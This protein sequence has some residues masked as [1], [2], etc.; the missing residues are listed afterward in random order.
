[1]K[2]SWYRLALMIVAI[3][4]AACATSQTARRLEK[5]VQAHYNQ[6]DF[7]TFYSWGL[8]HNR[9]HNVWT[10]PLTGEVT[11]GI[12]R[13]FCNYTPFFVLGFVPLVR[14]DLKPA[15]RVWL[16]IQMMGL[17]IAL[18]LATRALSPPPT[19]SLTVIFL[20]LMILS[21]PVY[22]MIRWGQMTGILMLPVALT[23][24]AS[25]RDNAPLVGLGVATAT[26]LKLFPGIMM[27]FFLL[28]RRWS[29]ALWSALFLVAGV[30]LSGVH[31]WI[32]FVT[33]GMFQSRL[34][35]FMHHEASILATVEAW[36]TPRG[37]ESSRPWTRIVVVAAV[38]DAIVLV[39]CV[40]ATLKTKRDELGS[41]LAL[42]LWITSGVLLSPLAWSHDFVLTAPLILFAIGLLSQMWLDSP[43][44][45]GTYGIGGTALLAIGLLF[46]AHRP[47][48]IASFW[49]GALLF[50]GS[51]LLLRARID[52]ST[53]LD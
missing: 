14:L 11:P 45:F 28:R 52:S 31:N 13:H 49:M 8:D 22:E 25:Q 41:G 5:S 47:S 10:Q 44:S 15:Y 40:W 46:G 30:L 16:G 42:G 23:L 36:L 9:G 27:L 33:R 26:L 12:R 2:S 7:T 29:V 20:S 39:T 38:A 3:T 37:M 51:A 18:W 53:G 35:P 1:M 32:D 4:L 50:A 43:G 34:G 6:N 24:F 48:A 19:V 21:E 17:M